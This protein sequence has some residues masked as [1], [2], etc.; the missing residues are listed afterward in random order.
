M[1]KFKTNRAIYERRVKDKQTDEG[2]KISLTSYKNS[3]DRS[4]LELFILYQ[5]V[6]QKSIAAIKESSLKSCIECK[7]VVKEKVYNLGLIE[8]DLKYLGMD[9]KVSSW[10]TQ[11]QKLVLKNQQMML[12]LG[13]STFI[14][15]RAQIAVKHIISKVKHPPLRKRILSQYELQKEEL[16]ED[17]GLFVRTSADEAKLIDRS[18]LSNSAIQPAESDTL[19]SDEEVFGIP[20]IN[21]EP[22]THDDSG[23][24]KESTPSKKRKRTEPDCLNPE[25][26]EQ[27]Y[28]KDCP[29]T[30]DSTKEKLWKEYR[31]TKKQ[32]TS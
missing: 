17:F 20:D 26:D 23:N 9:K 12:N 28:L 5:W 8:K 7:S 1:S 25:C 14:Q 13:Y 21:D 16:K 29:N 22:E 4:L 32:K 19:Y 10:E 31:E 15:I 2:V 3:I 27:H 24:D 11:T 30:D 6:P 18:E